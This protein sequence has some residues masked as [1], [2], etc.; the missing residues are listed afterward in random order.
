MNAQQEKAASKESPRIARHAQ[1]SVKARETTAAEK[2]A[3]HEYNDVTTDEDIIEPF[4]RAF[5]AGVAW[6]KTVERKGARWFEEWNRETE[7]MD[8]FLCYPIKKQGA[9]RQ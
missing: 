6:Q 2:W 4:K 7:H 1:N 9:K 8:E 3:R 5:L